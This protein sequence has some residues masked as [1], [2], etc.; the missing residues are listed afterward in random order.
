M[1]AVQRDRKLIDVWVRHII[2]DLIRL[3]CKRL[4]ARI[5]QNADKQ[6]F[7]QNET[8]TEVNMMPI[9]QGTDTPASQVVISCPNWMKLQDIKIKGP[10]VVIVYSFFPSTGFLLKHVHIQA[11]DEFKCIYNR[12]L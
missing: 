1:M 6:A 10:P 2:I 3:E 5:I 4:C 12:N 8:A 7:T 9:T 11:S